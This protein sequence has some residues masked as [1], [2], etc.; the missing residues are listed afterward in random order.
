[1]AEDV[2]AAERLLRQRRAEL[3][4]LILQMKSDHL[5]AGSVFQILNNELRSIEEKL[6][7]TSQLTSK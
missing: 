1:M 2:R 7:N 3:Q 6:K 4:Q 5:T